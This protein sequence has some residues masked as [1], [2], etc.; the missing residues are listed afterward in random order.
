MSEYK[1]LICVIIIMIILVLLTLQ[2]NFNFIYHI[3]EIS[4][5]AYSWFVL[6]DVSVIYLIWICSMIYIYICYLYHRSFIIILISE[7][8][9]NFISVKYNI[10]SYRNSKLI[11]YTVKLAECNLLR[12][13]RSRYFSFFNDSLFYE[14]FWNM[15]TY[16]NNNFFWNNVSYFTI[17]LYDYTLSKLSTLFGSDE[18]YIY[19]AKW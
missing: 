19:S 1:F 10:R 16:V 12:K 11:V 14:Q 7:N 15:I 8:R 4:F 6:F 3:W 9:N 13:T 17:T 5:R 2:R 18:E